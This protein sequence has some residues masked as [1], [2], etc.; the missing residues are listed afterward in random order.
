MQITERRNF[1]F[2]KVTMFGKLQNL[3]PKIAL[4]SYKNNHLTIA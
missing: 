3:S 4:N 1:G 2:T